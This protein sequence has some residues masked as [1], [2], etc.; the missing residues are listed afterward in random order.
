MTPAQTLRKLSTLLRSDD[1]LHIDQ[2][3]EL[4]I[5]L[6][7]PDIVRALLKGTRIAPRAK[8]EASRDIL[9]IEYSRWLKPRRRHHE[10]G[11]RYA[12]L[13]LLA[14]F[15]L[16]ETWALRAK[17]T[18]LSWGWSDYPL[19]FAP[20][21]ALRTLVISSPN[22]AVDLAQIASLPS[23]K[24]LAIQGDFADT[25]AL[26]SSSVE[27]LDVAGVQR[28]PFELGAFSALTRLRLAELAGLTDLSILR[29]SCGLVELDVESCGA[30]ASLAGI[31]GHRGLQTL[32]ARYGAFSS[33]EPLRGMHALT[34]LCLN[35]SPVEDIGAASTLRSLTRL[36]L[37]STAVRSLGALSDHPSLRDVAFDDCRSLESLVGLPRTA[38]ERLR[39][40]GT[41]SVGWSGVGS[42]R[43]LDGIDGFLAWMEELSIYECGS[44]ASIAALAGAHTLTALTLH[45]AGALRDLR[46]LHG[47]QRLARVHLFDAHRLTDLSALAG[48]TGLRELVL[49]GAS[50][51]SDLT[52]LGMVPSL[53]VLDL[54]G[55]GAVRDLSP[56]R[57]LPTLRTV[58]LHR[59][60][61]S[62]RSL[63]PALR[64]AASFAPQPPFRRMSVSAP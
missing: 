63:P 43:S 57:S 30:L 60:G 48:L 32:R 29:Q 13:R 15:D 44:L 4:A 6:R 8:G 41:A 31:E 35:G 21:R 22:V 33:I 52:P 7:T 25:A 28:K 47:C 40:T 11:V 54:R 64:S 50:S 61:V 59:T 37:S 2:G 49:Y 55:A 58:A 20:L 39:A 38:G 3:I 45:G 1:K 14:T 27:S 10:Q 9:T 18:G 24:R 26:A 23:L 12:L 5:S 36:D 53:E 46:G 62:R 51:L 42:L 34:E 56:L 17:L 16:P 19:D